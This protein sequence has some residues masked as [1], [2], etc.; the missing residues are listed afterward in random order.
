MTKLI[1]EIGINHDGSTN[2]A[3]KLIDIAHSANSWGI[4]FQ[5][6]NLRSY[7]DLSA[8]E[9]GNEIINNELSKNFLTVN[10]IKK[11]TKYARAKKLKVGCSFFSKNDSL[12]FK[13]FIF[14][15]YK[16]PSV[17]S[18][19]FQLIE[20]LKKKNKLLL[21]STGS[22]SESELNILA[23]K[24]IFNNNAVILHCISNYPL[25]YINAQLNIIRKLK[26]RFPSCSIG[27]S[28]HEE[29]INNCLISLGI[30]IDYLE[31]HITIDKNTI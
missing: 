25:H 29:E 11:L 23:K 16:I 9:I 1:C 18:L 19:D 17:S 10:T 30:G 6:R 14:D 15:F 5:Y 3:K 12:D 28:S 20:T 21:V 31:R 8:N 2:T 26:N 27:Y 13:D 4:K 24:K 7:K 22:L